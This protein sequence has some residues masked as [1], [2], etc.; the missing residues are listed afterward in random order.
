MNKEEIKNIIKS[1]FIDTMDLDFDCRVKYKSCSKCP[2]YEEKNG[3]S[4]YHC[5]EF[6][7]DVG[8]EILGEAWAESHGYAKKE[9]TDF[10]ETAAIAEVQK[11]MEK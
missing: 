5:S 7:E 9:T 1:E 3:E 6:Y 10:E 11:E 2:L 8:Q 4:V